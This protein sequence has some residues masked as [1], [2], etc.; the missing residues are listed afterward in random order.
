MEDMQE[1]E[2]SILASTLGLNCGER[3]FGSPIFLP[4]KCSKARGRLINRKV[5]FSEKL[6][7]IYL[8]LSCENVLGQSLPTVALV[9]GES[10]CCHCFVAQKLV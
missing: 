9:S 10:A 4:F 2:G 8:V 7:L 1:T 5:P 3:L 6:P